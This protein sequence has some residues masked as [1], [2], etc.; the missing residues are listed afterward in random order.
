MAARFFPTEAPVNYRVHLQNLAGLSAT[1]YTK[2]TVTVGVTMVKAVHIQELRQRVIETLTANFTTISYSPTTNR[3]TTAGVTYDAAGQMLTDANF[4]GLQYQY[5]PEGRMTWSANLDGSNPSTSVYDGLGQ[6]VQTTQAGVTRTFIYDINGSV[7]AEYETT[8]GTGYGALKRLNVCAGGR[9]LAVD[10]VQ[11][12]GTKVTSY[13]MADRQGSTRVLMDA[14]GAV[15]SRHDYLPFGEELGAG[16]G[17]PGSPTG[18]RTAAQGYSAADNVRQRYAD[19]RLDEATGLDHTLWRKLE[20][21]SG[22]WTTPD[23][24]GR[25]MRVPDPQSFNRYA[26]VHNDPVNFVD[27]SGLNEEGPYDTIITT[28]TWDWNP[29][30]NPLYWRFLFWSPG[31]GGGSPEVGNTGGGGAPP[32]DPLGDEDLSPDQR[33]IVEG[34]DK[35]IKDLLKNKDCRELIQGGPD[36]DPRITQAAPRLDWLENNRGITYFNGM[37]F[38]AGSGPAIAAVRG[39]YTGFGRSSPRIVLGYYFF[40]EN[41]G[42]FTEYWKIDKD[43]ARDLT[44]IH[45]LMHDLTRQPHSGSSEDALNQEILKTCMG[46]TRAIPKP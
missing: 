21:R 8:E 9:L 46:M 38:N 19:T 2:P 40:Q 37:E 16:T 36:D 5:N 11:T 34:I 14:A 29:W 23:P 45:E 33:K 44:L 18:M 1:S 35:T 26:Y 15:T 31:G 4:R 41:V 22:R 12:D 30:S 43:Q 7:A 3:I 17:A 27:P 32:P 39:T 20:T 6:R 28:D 24:Y 25:S 10:E 42:G 13:L